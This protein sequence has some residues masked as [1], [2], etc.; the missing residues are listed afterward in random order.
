MYSIAVISLSTHTA[1]SDKILYI[2]EMFK[3][4]I[5]LKLRNREEFQLNDNRIQMPIDKDS[6]V[7]RKIIDIANDFC[8]SFHTYEF[9]EYD[10]EEIHNAQYFQ[11]FVND[12]LES[13]GTYARDYG[14]KYINNCSACKIGGILDGDVLVDRK[15]VRKY[16]IASL[17]PDIF[18]SK[19]V[20]WLIETNDLTGVDFKHVVRDYKGREIPEYYV[21]SFK[22]TMPPMDSRTWLSFDP[23]AKTCKEC[24]TEIPYLKSHC[25]YNEFDFKYAH[26]FNLTSEI[27]N[28]FEERGIIVSK[29][30]KEIFVKS[31]IRVG[32]SM[33]NIV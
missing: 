22:H 23:P 12:P 6:Q 13:E 3:D 1:N 27:Y 28:N 16:G 8:I 4:F 7:F 33:L 10:Q 25:Y 24:G 18:V 2:Y 29:K 20:K 15:F 19:E 17:R 9:T 21:M 11:M 5:P 14:T 32:Y 26:D 31:K 30:V